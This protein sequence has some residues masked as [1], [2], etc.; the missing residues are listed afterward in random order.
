MLTPI[1]AA[2]RRRSVD[3]ETEPTSL[4]TD[5]PVIYNFSQRDILCVDR[6]VRAAIAG[7]YERM[8]HPKGNR[9]TASQPKR[10][11]LAEKRGKQ[12]RS[13]VTNGKQL[14]LDG[15][16]RSRASRRFRDLLAGI[17]SDLGGVN[18]LSVGQTQ[19]ARRCALLSVQCEIMEAAAVDGK[20]FDLDQYGQLTDRLGRAFQRLGLR[21]QPRDITPALEAYLSH[22]DLVLTEEP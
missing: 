1:G 8:P 2:L 12:S 22:Q 11:V 15:E 3:G 21:R 19:L 10:N 6:A 20:D 17:A 5:P 18:E 7:R 13:R 14:F 16:V 4:P 9:T